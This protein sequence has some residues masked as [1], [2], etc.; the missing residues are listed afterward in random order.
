[1]TT[2][3][4]AM[5]TTSRAT[6]AWLAALPLRVEG[7]ELTVLELAVDD[8][9]TRLMT[10]VHLHGD[11]QEG[12]GED[13]TYAPVPQLAFRAAE[14]V[15]P[16]AG[17]WTLDSF[18]AHLGTLDLFPAGA[19]PPDFL[20][21]AA[22]RLRAR[23]WTLPYAKPGCRWPSRSVAR[24]DPSRLLSHRGPQAPVDTVDA[25]LTLYPRQRFK[26]MLSQAWDDASVEALAS[27]G[28][29]DVVDLKRQYDEAVPVAVRPDPRL[30]RRVLRAFDKAWIEDPGVSAA[31]EPVLRDH[32]DRI[33]WDVPIRAAADIANRRVKPRMINMKPSRFGSVRALMDAYDHCARSGS[34]RT[35]ADGSRWDRG[36]RRSSC[37]RPSFTPTP[38]R[39]SRPAPSTSACCAADCRQPAAARDAAQRL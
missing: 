19:G 6:Y 1:M 35:A 30:Y 20:T 16:L 38:Q 39:T 12:H 26:P 4:T 22:G 31:T 15:L 8:D 2:A 29:V 28:M 21:S 14:P 24:H 34:R 32:Y 36:G 23:H 5:A 18:S 11:R 13:T 17:E 10:V 3:A 27:T 37:S 9:Y 25:H 7:Y 33:A